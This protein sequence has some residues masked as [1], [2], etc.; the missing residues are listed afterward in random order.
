MH[1]PGVLNEMVDRLVPTSQITF[2]FH[3]NVWCKLTLNFKRLER[4]ESTL[5]CTQTHET[6]QHR[7]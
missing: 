4:S 6:Q 2:S 3:L 7:T 1:T 5:R